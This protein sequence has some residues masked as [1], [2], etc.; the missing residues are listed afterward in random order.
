M[1]VRATR[2][3]RVQPKTSV[4]PPAAADNSA[5]AATVTSACTGQFMESMSATSGRTWP[6]RRS[7][8]FAHACQVLMYGSDADA[9]VADRGGYPFD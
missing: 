9:T 4:S 1:T 3:I 6:S 2:Q 8:I 5:P 7:L